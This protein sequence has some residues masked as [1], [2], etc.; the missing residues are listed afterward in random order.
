M[1]SFDAA[2]VGGAGYA[3]IQSAL[4]KWSGVVGS[5][6]S[7]KPPEAK[8]PAPT[9]KQRQPSPTPPAPPSEA[10]PAKPKN[11]WWRT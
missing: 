10:P 7:W 3:P 2:L 11:P 1:A 6:G 5:L 9:G 8:P 4:D